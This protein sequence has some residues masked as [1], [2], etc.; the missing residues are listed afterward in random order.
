[1][2]EST[3]ASPN[4]STSRDN[5]IRRL[6]SSMSTPAHTEIPTIRFRRGKTLRCSA[7]TSS[8]RTPRRRY[9]LPDDSRAT[10]TT[11]WIK[12]LPRPLPSQGE[13]AAATAASHVMS[14]SLRSLELW[15]GVECTH[16]R[17]GDRYFDQLDRTGH[18]ARIEDL[19][20]IADT[21]IR[22]IRYPVL[23]ERVAPSGLEPDWRWADERLRRV[24]DLG[25]RPIVGLLHHGSG[26]PTTSLL[27][28]G[29]P[30]KFAAY[31][32]AFAERYPW[33]DAYAPIN[34]PL[35]TARFAGLY[36]IWHPHG[37]DEATFARAFINQCRA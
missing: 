21:G 29:F 13:S 12:S 22:A 15:G 31:A 30:A 18:G 11:T 7:V 4:S 17:V 6:A 16:N 36:G 20:L 2:R 27:D 24:R 5:V 33:V 9:I 14:L 10:S 1:M 37:T 23:W 8:L 26:P 25:M 32:R 34:E 19:D 3:R 35:T 28:P